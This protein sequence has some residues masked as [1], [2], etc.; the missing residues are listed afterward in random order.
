MNTVI[1]AL[2]IIFIV[3]LFQLIYELVTVG[4]Y[5]A[6]GRFDPT[7]VTVLAML[8]ISMFFL[9]AIV[10]VIHGFTKE[11]KDMKKIAQVASKVV[12]P[13]VTLILVLGCFY[14]FPIKFNIL[15]ITKY[16]GLLLAAFFTI[17]LDYNLFGK[18]ST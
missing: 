1:K 3:I 8:A 10:L 14:L 6:H 18:S 15:S 7:D 4:V 9:A 5:G 2:R 11:F 13:I 16:G 17:Y 12:F